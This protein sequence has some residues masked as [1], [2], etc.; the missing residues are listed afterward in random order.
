M[1]MGFA[2]DLFNHDANPVLVNLSRAFR[3]RICRDD[4]VLNA[5]SGLFNE[6]PRIHELKSR[7]SAFKF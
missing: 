5:L 7:G 2:E 6:K 4:S 1:I 3:R